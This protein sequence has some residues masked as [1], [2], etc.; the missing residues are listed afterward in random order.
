MSTVFDLFR[1]LSSAL[2]GI[3]ELLGYLLR[4]LSV[5]VQSRASRAARRLG[6]DPCS[7]NRLTPGS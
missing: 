7:R 1:D 2:G 3:G 4:F 5:F 6:I